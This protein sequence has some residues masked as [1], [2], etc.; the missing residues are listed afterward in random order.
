MNNKNGS[1]LIVTLGFILIFTLLGLAAMHLSG[2]QNEAAVK[3]AYSTKAFWLADAGVQVGKKRLNGNICGVFRQ[4]NAAAGGACTG[5]GCSSCSNCG[6]NEKCLNE[7]FTANGAT[8]G[9]YFVVIN[10]S[11]TV[12]TS[13]G[14]AYSNSAVAS[15]KKQKR[16]IRVTGSPFLFS[17]FGINGVTLGNN[18]TVDSYNSSKLKSDGTPCTYGQTCADGTVNAGSNGDIGTNG[19]TTGAISLGYNTTVSG[20]LSTG[21]NGTVSPGRPMIGK[22]ISLS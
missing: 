12:I 16:K 19:T 4:Y 11:N 6:S 2:V 21:V 18:N 8:I 14:T 9:D 7:T 22:S 13:T 3:Q 10:K 15:I 17:I 20:D 1:I 5:T